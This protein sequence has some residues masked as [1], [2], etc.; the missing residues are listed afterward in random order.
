MARLILRLF[1]WLFGLACL[2]VVI[3]WLVLAAPFFSEFRRDIVAEVLTEQM[4]QPILVQED[5][6]VIVGPITRVRAGGVVIPSEDMSDQVL[7]QLD[8][9]ELD[10]DMIAV[11]RGRINLDNL[12]VGGLQL[13]LLTQPDGTTSWSAREK[14]HRTP[15]PQSETATTP[16]PEASGNE[17]GILSFLSNKTVSFEQVGL[18]IDNQQ[19]GFSFVF[20]LQELKLDQ[21][22]GGQTPTVTGAGSVNGEDFAIDG[23]YPRGGDFTTLA[24]FGEIRLTYDGTVLPDDQG[25]GYTGNLTLDTGELGEFLDFIGLERVFEGRGTLSAMITSQTELL[26]IAEFESQLALQTGQEINL[27]GAFDNV[28]TKSGLD[29]LFTARFHP[30]GRPP[31]P[32]REL[33]DLKLTGLRAH[34]TGTTGAMEFEEFLMTTNAFDQGLDEVGPVSISRI[35]RTPDGLLAMEGISLQAGPRDLPYLRAEG[36]ILNLL[37]LQALKFDGALA[38]PA[39]F[40][41]TGLSED[42]AT[43]FGGIEADFS[44]DDT[45]GHLSLNSLNAKA[46]DTDIWKLDAQ[47]ELGDVATLD[48]IAIDITLGILDGADFLSAL[49]LE[50]VDT[51]PLGFRFSAMGKGKDFDTSMGV[52]AGETRLNATLST[53]VT[54]GRPNIKGRL[55]SERVDIEDVRKAVAAA[56]QLGKIG[57]DPELEDGTQPLVLPKD[58]DTQD[59]DVQPLVLPKEDRKPTD[60]VDLE[61]LFLETDLDVKVEIEEIVGQQG[62]SSVSSELTAV[63]GKARLGPLEV[64]YGGGYFR[65]AAAMDLIE[66]PQLVSV[67]GA[68][69]GW[70]FGRILDSVG[71]GIDA[72]GTLSGNF[73]VTGNRQNIR[74][75]IDTMVGSAAIRMD[76]GDIATSLLELAGLGI[77]PWL[78]SEEFRQG[79]TEIVCVVAPVNINAGRVSFDSIVA[80]TK[81]V[82]LVAKGEVNWKADTI[83][84][85]AEPRRVGKPLSRSAWPFDVTGQLS[86]PKFKLDVGGSRSSRGDDAD[87]MPADRK[88]CVPDLNQLQ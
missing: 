68:T 21:A 14:I 59:D 84:L 36:E 42:K 26:Q 7:A 22:D 15:E 2:C 10:V 45:K 9:L 8:V 44:I 81:S 65:V 4:G 39:A 5:V 43:Q 46:V 29:L 87:A 17:S 41:L 69:S 71:L 64:G 67:S 40:V 11:L 32:A 47:V 31:A 57:D 33:K 25:G 83:A 62:V 52:A 70:D 75:F 58:T 1:L 6:S 49:S 66:T 24:T 23:R 61:R 27:T 12:L 77:F 16:E 48:D 63:E 82:Q 85:R 86:A 50:A 73:D 56:V 34:V 54:E 18:T 74:T 19:T 60:L 20:D 28:L 37:E 35:R 88:P 76:Q 3:G 53:A 51:G 13:N 72:H 55:H 30:E 78:F 79:Y 38:V 80:E